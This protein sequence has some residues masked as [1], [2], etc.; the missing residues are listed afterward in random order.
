[1]CH[2]HYS[3]T[4]RTMLTEQ[5]LTSLRR[6]G[7]QIENGRLVP[8]MTEKAIIRAM[9]APATAWERSRQRAWITWAWQT[10]SRWFANG[11]D[12]IPERITPVLCDARYP[13]FRDLF[14]LV[15]LSWS[16]P[17]SRGC[18]RRMRFVV[19]DAAIE[20]V[21]GI[22]GFQSPPLSF[23]ARDRR[24]TYPPGKKPLLVNQ[25]LDIHTLGAIPPYDRLLGGKL[26]AYLAVSN[27][28]RAQYRQRYHQQRTI[29]ANRV[30]PPDVVAY[31]TVGAFG[32]SSMYER[33][34]YRNVPLVISLG[35]TE[36]YG[37]F[38]LTPWYRSLRM[39]LREQGID[40]QT[41]LQ[42]GP[43]RK[44]QLITMALHS[45]GLPSSL[46]RHGIRRHAYLFPLIHNLDEYMDGRDETPIV[47]D[48]PL[49]D[50]V[51]WWKERWL[52]P[53][54]QRVPDWKDA[55]I[56]IL[57]SRLFDDTGNGSTPDCDDAVVEGTAC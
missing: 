33:L 9:H 2:D 40:D 47:R 18:G 24:W 21:I 36:G 29:V 32:K 26:L 30:L 54:A 16:V 20:K 17:F 14:R 46:L 39:L 52:L 48:Y 4:D 50:L 53:R 28:V 35:A 27:E 41:G 22:L 12:V 42:H 13:P 37:V 19:I 44:W 31:T 5:I 25:T 11:T 56:D 55:T 23:P 57:R 6:L 45:L 15:R 51:A 43:R 3:T 49:V 34:T 38:H 8:P 10:Y 1:V 7:F